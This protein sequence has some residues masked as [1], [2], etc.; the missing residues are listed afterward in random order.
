MYRMTVANLLFAS[1]VHWADVRRATSTLYTEQSSRS[2]QCCRLAPLR[3]LYHSKPRLVRE[4]EG[5]TLLSWYPRLLETVGRMLMDETHFYQSTVKHT[6]RKKLTLIYI[7]TIII[8]Y[9]STK[10]H[11]YNFCQ[12]S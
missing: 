1:V 6:I 2:G 9:M 7:C 12:R 8:L 5:D 3:I 11:I 10:Y 4:R